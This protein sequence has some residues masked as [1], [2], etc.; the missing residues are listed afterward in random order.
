MRRD[1]QLSAQPKELKGSAA[2]CTDQNYGFVERLN[3]TQFCGHNPYTGGEPCY[4]WCC[5]SFL[6]CFVIFF[7]E[8]ISIYLISKDHC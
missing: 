2:E 3:K 6:L 5:G 7:H 8:L 1:L 4:I